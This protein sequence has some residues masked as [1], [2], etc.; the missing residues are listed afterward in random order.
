MGRSI[1]VTLNG[2]TYPTKG[3]ATEFL[4]SILYSYKIG[5]TISNPAHIAALNDLLLHHPEAAEKI[6]VGIQS[7]FVGDGGE[8]GGQCFWIRRTDT[9]T[10]DFSFKRCL[11]MIK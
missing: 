3:K 8:H 7:F 5:Q 9:S 6:G 2:I 1:P 4:Q 11:E 10:D